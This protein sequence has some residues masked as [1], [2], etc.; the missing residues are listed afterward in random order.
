MNSPIESI[1]TTPKR[2]WF[3]FAFNS[4]NFARTTLSKSLCALLL[5]MVPTYSSARNDDQLD[6]LSA[7]W[8][9]QQSEI[10]TAYL[11][12]RRFFRGDV[13]QLSIEEVEEFIQN[14]NIGSDL[15]NMA[16]LIDN[17]MSAPLQTRPPWSIKESFFQG[18]RIR[19]QYAD[20]A[21][22]TRVFDGEAELNHDVKNNNIQVYQ[23]G[24]SRLHISSLHEFRFVPQPDRSLYETDGD[25]GPSIELRWGP[26]GIIADRETGIIRQAILRTERGETYKRMTQ[27]CLVTYPGGIVFP[28]LVIKETYN[29]GRLDVLELTWIEEAR[30]NEDHP[31]GTFRL[32]APAGSNVL[33]ERQPDRIGSFKVS[34]PLADVKHEVDARIAPP[35]GFLA[36]NLRAIALIVLVAIGCA[37][38]W[39]VVLL[40]SRSART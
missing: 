13:K 40:R 37:F 16:V 21:N 15:E 9:R 33:D 12:Y 27:D 18:A 39:M 28:S 22:L 34:T 8:E 20:G 29:R 26:S 17:V 1:V 30:F 23:P 19:E 11:K 5:L 32:G 35:P 38:A 6:A 7:L 3:Y 24:G 4:A 14:A 31:D 2:T 10:T 36:R 25:V